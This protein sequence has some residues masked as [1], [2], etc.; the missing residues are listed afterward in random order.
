MCPPSHSRYIQ[1]KLTFMTGGGGEKNNKLFES[2]VLFFWSTDAR[3]CMTLKNARNVFDHIFC[4]HFERRYARTVHYIVITHLILYTIR[5]NRARANCTREMTYV[6][7]YNV[8]FFL[9]FFYS[10][11]R[12]KR[13]TWSAFRARGSK[14]AASPPN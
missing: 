14:F 7:E 3:Q 8:G 6:Y 1:C 5:S 10:F 9:F 4:F 13:A 12:T 2:V 11:A